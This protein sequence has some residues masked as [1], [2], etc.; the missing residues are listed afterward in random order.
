MSRWYTYR[1][2]RPHQRA[3]F[4]LSPL[5]RDRAPGRRRRNERMLVQVGAAL[6]DLLSLIKRRQPP[7]SVVAH[8]R[9]SSVQLHP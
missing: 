1:R 3:L 4:G 2:A 7:L 6:D 5:Q 9:V 8:A